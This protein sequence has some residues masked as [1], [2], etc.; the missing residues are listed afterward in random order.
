ML[1]NYTQKN[2]L[3]IQSAEL[4]Q[5]FMFSFALRKNHMLSSN[6]ELD[7]TLPNVP[8]SYQTTPS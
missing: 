7:L 5:K 3:I 2:I 8:M 1:Q 4:S 6:F